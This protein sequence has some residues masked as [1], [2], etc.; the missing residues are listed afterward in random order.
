MVVVALW[1]LNMA[2]SF[3]AGYAFAVSKYKQKI[4]DFVDKHTYDQDDNPPGSL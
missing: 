2:L 3:W 1:F 4:E